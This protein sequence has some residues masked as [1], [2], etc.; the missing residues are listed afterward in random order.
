MT[1]AVPPDD[2]SVAP[3]YGVPAVPDGSD[4]VVTLSG[5]VIVIGSVAVDTERGE[6]ESVAV[7]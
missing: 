4:V 1:G 7:K 3:G 5:P 2:C 6:P